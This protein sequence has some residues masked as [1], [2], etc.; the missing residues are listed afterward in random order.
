MKSDD[1]LH[2]IIST[3]YV[4]IHLPK[5]YKTINFKELI[6]TLMKTN[7]KRSNKYGSID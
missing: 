6:V 5:Y 7:L 1:V 2:T 3:M 4:Q